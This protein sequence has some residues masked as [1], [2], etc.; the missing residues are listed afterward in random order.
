[1]DLSGNVYVNNQIGI[2]Q[3][4]HG[5][6][7]V[8]D[9]NQ[10]VH[11]APIDVYPASAI[12]RGGG[13][14]SPIS[15]LGGSL[16][17]LNASTN[18]AVDSSG[19]IFA[20]S[21]LPDSV[22]IF[23]R[24]SNGNLAPLATIIGKETKLDTPAAI[25]VDSV[26]KIYVANNGFGSDPGGKNGA[27][28]TIYPPNSDGNVRPIGVISGDRTGLYQPIAIGVDPSGNIYA[29]NYGGV[30]VT[31]YAPGTNGNV[32]PLATIPSGGKTSG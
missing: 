5:Q 27:R 14:V 18:L 8:A 30:T 2:N 17:G 9:I 29:A 13:D 31:V 3:C 20:T 1:V 26:G 22:R 24:G 6:S 21:W 12:S 15:I 7:T 16:T 10:D 25:A 4:G 19:K 32:A 11:F 28:I 23:A